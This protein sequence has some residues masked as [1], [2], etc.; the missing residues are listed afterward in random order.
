MSL[1]IEKEE[2]SGGGD[3]VPITFEVTSHDV[4][5]PSEAKDKPSAS[6]QQV[7][8]PQL[9]R[10]ASPTPSTESEGSS[11]AEGGGRPSPPPCSL[12]E[13]VSQRRTEDSIHLTLIFSLR[14]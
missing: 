7:P 3:Q 10:S 5:A 14:R 1:Q 2:E 13:R 4:V 6:P 8:S 12:R 11:V 9:S